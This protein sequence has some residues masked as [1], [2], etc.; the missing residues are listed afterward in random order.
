MTIKEVARL[1]GVSQASV[2]RY[3]NGG[4]LSESKRLTIEETIK[5]TGYRPSMAARV[6]RHGKVNQIGVIVPKMFYSNAG[7]QIVEG[8][9]EI[10]QD[11][12]YMVVLGNTKRV[13]EKEKEYIALMQSN[14]AAGMIIMGTS[15]SPQIED[16]YRASKIP[17]VITG[18]KIKGLHCVYH[19]DYKAMYELTEMVLDR[20]RK[21]IAFIGVGDDDPQAGSARHRAAE[22]AY[23]AH[24]GD[25]KDLIYVKADFDVQSGHQA[26]LSLLQREPDIDGLICATD[27][28][29]LGALS[30]MLRAGKK[31]G[32]D[33]SIVGVGNSWVHDYSV[34]PLTTAHCFYKECGQEAA[35]MLLEMIENSGSDDPVPVRQ[36]CM[37]YRIM[38]RGSV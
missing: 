31:P 6:M 4:P 24:R 22:D 26:M 20:G 8:I 38:D 5:E 17:L 1:A 37:E 2:S 10:V 25:S 18:Q 13:I 34:T 36:T 9:T 7:S 3:L 33:F 14:R 16:I 30:V 23:A 32:D 28:I 11:R 15:V 27:S 29:A 19:N 12:G 35:R 21:K